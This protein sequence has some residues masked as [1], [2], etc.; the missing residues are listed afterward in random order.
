MKKTEVPGY[1]E[2]V[3]QVVRTTPKLLTSEQI[4]QRVAALRPIETRSPSATIRGVITLCR[5]IARGGEAGYGWYPR[6]INGASVRVPL[7]AEE[8][9]REFIGLD[10]LAR[11]LLCPSFFAEQSLKQREPITLTLPT[12]ERIHPAL[13]LQHVGQ[14]DWGTE[15]TPEFWRWLAQQQPH[16][17]DSLILTCE[18]GE[19]RTYR[20]EYEATA[21]RDEAALRHH[22]HAVTHAAREYLWRNRA[23]GSAPWDLA[24][25][26]LA[27]GQY[28][29]TVPPAPYNQIW[30]RVE[31]ERMI[32]EAAAEMPSRKTAAA[33]Q[34]YQL[35]VQLQDIHPPIW[36]RI[37]VTDRTTLAQLHWIIQLTLGWTNSHLHQFTIDG[38]HYSDPAFELDEED[39]D[40]KDTNALT[41]G[42]LTKRAGKQ[43][44]YEYDFGDSWRHD[45]TVEAITSLAKGEAPLRCLAGER[46][47]PPEDCG[48]IGGYERLRTELSDVTSPERDSLCLWLGGGFDAEAFDAAGADW[49]LN[50]LVTVFA[51]KP[52]AQ[53]KGWYR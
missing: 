15:A 50:K 49:L 35:L 34:A 38:V 14:G 28:H 32:L 37:V 1:A 53:K 33:R 2:L 51:Q 22:T 17:G 16:S 47:C 48:G 46:A 21:A 20:V 42:K 11:D 18:D 9:D 40:W 43:F 41:L 26:L 27:S 5:L 3:R 6:M 29:H 52:P 25:H 10:D 23:H 31:A 36:R 13:M 45:T 30:N 44:S 4:T 39:D 24:Q 12:G 19:A 7:F 8:F